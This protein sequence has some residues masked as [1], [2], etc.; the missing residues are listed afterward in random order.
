MLE[1][2][3][4][5]FD[6]AAFGDLALKTRQEAPPGRA[7]FIQRQGVCGFR[8]GGPQEGA[9]LHDIDAILAVVIM[10]VAAAPTH[11]VVSR[12]GIAHGA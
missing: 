9:E 2:A 3:A 6:G 8:L 11:A 12:W 10:R 7:V 1:A 5:H 4:Q